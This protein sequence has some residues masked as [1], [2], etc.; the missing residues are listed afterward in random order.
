MGNCTGIFASCQGEDSNPVNSVRKI[1]QNAMQKALQGNPKFD[2]N[3][4]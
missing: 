3:I 4:N 2:N 1:D